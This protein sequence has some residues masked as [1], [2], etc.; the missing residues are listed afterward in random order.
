MPNTNSSSAQE[1][2]VS[3]WH[4]TVEGTQVEETE[5]EGRTRGERGEKRTAEALRRGINCAG[6]SHIPE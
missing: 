4:N 1:A 6:T 2:S 3:Q 5:E